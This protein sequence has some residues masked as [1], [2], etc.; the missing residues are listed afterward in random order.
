MSRVVHVVRALAGHVCHGYRS[1]DLV[2]TPRRSL[3]HGLAWSLIA[4]GMVLLLVDLAIVTGGPHWPR[5]WWYILGNLRGLS[6]VLGA[7]F[8]T[9][10]MMLALPGWVMRPRQVGRSAT[11][12]GV[13]R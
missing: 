2:N 8:T 13:R 10:G 7:M 9:L 4:T 12:S 5:A 1:T 6:V 11:P 3:L